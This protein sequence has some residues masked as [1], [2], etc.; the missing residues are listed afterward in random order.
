LCRYKKIELTVKGNYTGKLLIDEA[1]I[2]A[3]IG[4]YVEDFVCGTP[5]NDHLYY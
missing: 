4:I 1:P 2:E 3:Y 5:Y